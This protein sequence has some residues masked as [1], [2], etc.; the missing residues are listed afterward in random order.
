MVT[1][2]TLARAQAGDQEAFRELTDAYRAEL[3]RHGYQILGSVQDAE[4]MLQDTLLAAWR[5]LSTFEGRSSVRAWLYKIAVNR[6]LNALRGRSRR[7]R[8]VPLT[9]GPPEPTRQARPVWV[10]PYPDVLLDGVP[11]LPPGPETPYDTKEPIELP[12]IPPLPHLPPPHP[13]PLILLH[14]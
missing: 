3:L 11:D 14:L 10:E 2:S 6:C 4:D 5:G 9:A 7:P 12:F 8:E 1:P 13:P